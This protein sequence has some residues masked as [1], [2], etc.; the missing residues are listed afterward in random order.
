MVPTMDPEIDYNN[1]DVIVKQFCSA[2]HL[3][4]LTAW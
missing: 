2:E 4:M 3:V 1:N